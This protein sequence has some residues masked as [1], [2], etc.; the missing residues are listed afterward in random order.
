MARNLPRRLP[1]PV[2]RSASEVET[3]ARSCRMA[4]SSEKARGYTSRMPLARPVTILTF[5]LLGLL[6]VPPVR[7]ARRPIKFAVDAGQ[8]KKG[9]EK[10]TCF[11]IVFP[12][13][14]A[15]D[16]DQVQIF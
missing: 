16:V 6:V 10:Q 1:G 3:R 12:R 14:E 9:T 5:L 11:P 8:V 7:A 2:T 15:I 13:R 4:L